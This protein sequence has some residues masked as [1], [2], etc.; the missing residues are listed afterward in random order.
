[1]SK[2]VVVTYSKSRQ[3]VTRALHQYDYG[4]ILVFSGEEFPELYEVHFS[5]VGDT[6]TTVVFGNNQGVRIPDKYL[7]TGDDINA[8]I[9]SHVR[10]CDGESVY[11]V[12]I[13]VI[14]RG[15]FAGPDPQTPVEYIFDGRDASDYDDIMPCGTID[16]GNASDT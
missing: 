9:Y 11:K 15:A 2:R 12:L 6:K 16:G 13:P 4:Q 1:M 7:K 14:Q 3:S 10:A 5:N 8:W